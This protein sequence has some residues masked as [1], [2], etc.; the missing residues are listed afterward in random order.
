MPTSVHG[1]EA[2][3]SLSQ[4]PRPG[5]R[6]AAGFTLIELMVVI[7]IIAMGAAVTSLAMRDPADARLERE[8]ARLSALLE[9]ARAEARALGLPVVWAPATSGTLQGGQAPF[10]FVGFPPGSTW[11]TRWLGDGVSAEVLGAPN[12]VLGPE[13]LIGP[14]R[15]VLR[16]ERQQI[17]LATDGL[18][19]FTPVALTEPDAPPAAR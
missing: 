9:A 3:A 15:I 4:L 11:P 2:V 7:T 18:G 13:P 1:S 19:P 6:A 14:Q 8:A 16:L 5:R 12:V 10:R 17:A